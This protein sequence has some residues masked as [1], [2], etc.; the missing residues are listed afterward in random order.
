MRELK[1]GH[2][3]SLAMELFELSR[4]EIFCTL[5][6]CSDALLHTFECLTSKWKACCQTDDLSSKYVRP[7]QFLILRCLCN[8]A[9]SLRYVRYDAT[10]KR[11]TK[12]KC[13]HSSTAFNSSYLKLEMRFSRSSKSTRLRRLCHDCLSRRVLLCRPRR[14]LLPFCNEKIHKD[15]S[16]QYIQNKFGQEIW[17]YKLV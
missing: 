13:K 9:I 4:I 16:I 1:T 10:S 7:L 8:F 6:G 15:I 12:R 14:V 3:S 17:I 2:A 11:T 5:R